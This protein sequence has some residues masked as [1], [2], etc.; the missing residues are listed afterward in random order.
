MTA[1]LDVAIAFAGGATGGPIVV[2]R[3]PGDASP[4][5]S[6]HADRLIDEYLTITGSLTSGTATITW[7]FDPA[8]DDALAGAL[9]TVFQ[10]NG[11]TLSNAYSVTPSGNTLTIGP[12]NSF[13]D[14]YAG[15]NDATAAE[16]QLLDN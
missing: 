5:I 10:F 14:W 1:N 6:Y 8:S 12:V 11:A 15:S 7:N 13:S 2:S 4:A 16:W 3:T 9:D